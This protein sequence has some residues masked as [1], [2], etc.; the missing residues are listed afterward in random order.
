[1]N[2]FMEGFFGIQQ[3]IRALPYFPEKQL[4]QFDT[5]K[6]VSKITT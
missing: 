3:R 2:V 5:L 6:V 1:M 4:I